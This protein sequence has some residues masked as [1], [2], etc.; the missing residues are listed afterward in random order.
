MAEYNPRL[1][2]RFVYATEGTYGPTPI[3]K[4]NPRGFNV[5]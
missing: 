2:E 3:N 4:N 1:F 5:G